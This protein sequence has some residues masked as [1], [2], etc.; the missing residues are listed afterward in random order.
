MKTWPWLVV[1]YFF[2]TFFIESTKIGWYQLFLF[3]SARQSSKSNVKALHEAAFKIPQ[4]WKLKTR[5][6]KNVT[7]KAMRV[8]FTAEPREHRVKV[9]F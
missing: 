5:L 6:K 9:P 7:S 3:V 4:I 8:K 2:F 1:R